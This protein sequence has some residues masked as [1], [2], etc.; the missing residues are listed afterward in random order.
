MVPLHPVCS[1][2]VRCP[3]C[4][5]ADLPAG[6]VRLV[7]WHLLAEVDCPGCGLAFDEDVPHG[8]AL[9]YPAR[10]ARAD[11]RPLPPAVPAWYQDGL[12]EARR[13]PR[14]AGEPPAAV[15]MAGQA[16][17]RRV[18]LVNA[19]DHVYGHAVLKLLNAQR[20]LDHPRGREVV[21]LIPAALDWMIPA[22]V[23]ERW[24]I[25]LPWREINR[26]D[27]ALDAWFAAQLA[28][29]D[30]VVLS[31]SYLQPDFR[32]LDPAR[33]FGV[34]AFALDTFWKRP[35]VV[36][37]VPRPDRLWTDAQ[38]LADLADGM[39]RVPALRVFGP[40]LRHRQHA[41]L[42]ATA[43][44]MRCALPGLTVRVAG[45]GRPGGLPG[46]IEDLRDPRPT[47]ERERAWCRAYAESHVVVGV[48]G[49]NLILPSALAAG[50]VSI[51]PR[52]RFPNFG[53]DIAVFREGRLGHYLSRHLP[54]GTPART[55]ADTVIELIRCFP[56]VWLN[57]APE[58]TPE[59]GPADPS[60]NADF[61]HT[62]VAPWRE[63]RR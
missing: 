9:N 11:G 23:A 8:L 3:G 45:P 60:R 25:H 36:T 34:P 12:V 59:D 19:L 39:G 22:G 27:P 16:R 61:F 20:H 62:V 40:L 4:G 58:F 14:T 13:R 57:A 6:R 26:A 5:R 32:A 52:R 31:P 33:F 56:N 48:H 15:D 53:Q 49:S 18:V 42:A 24:R 29:F 55:V 35:P 54:L 10:L 38:W 46:W 44:R 63:G 50:V 7:G 37:F 30:E 1:F 21:V 47:P 43:R 51:L 2:P 17:G 28:R 41:L